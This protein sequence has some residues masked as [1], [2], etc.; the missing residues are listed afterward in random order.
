[1][2]NSRIYA[3]I[4]TAFVAILLMSWVMLAR[5]PD[6]PVEEVRESITV[7]AL[8]EAHELSS[9]DALARLRTYIRSYNPYDVPRNCLEI[10]SGD[11]DYTFEVVNRCSAAR[12]VLGKWR[13]DKLTRAVLRQR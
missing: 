10:R 4:F 7:T 5:E 3:S 12:E 6:T 8:A 2:R 11:D 9:A 1:M 13:V